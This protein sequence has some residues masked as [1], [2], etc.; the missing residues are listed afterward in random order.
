VVRGGEEE[1]GAGRGLDHLVA[2][3]LGAVIDGDGTG[4]ASGG[5][6]E[7]D[8]DAVEFGDGSSL[9]LA[10]HDVAGL[11]VDE[12]DDAVLVG[13]E[14]GVTLEVSDAGAVLGAGWPLGDHA[15]AG[16]AASRV[17]VT[18]AFTALLLGAP[19]V[20]V[21]EAALSSALPDVA[22]DGLVADAELA[23]LGEP[24]R[25]LLGAPLFLEASDH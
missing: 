7:P 9:E 3:E 25:D 12:R 13:A 2:V 14:H 16:Q 1:V 20:K 8:R 19:E 24:A 21:E 5:V 4:A 22:V 17:I 11:P 15:F 18:V 10:D 23:T 6:D